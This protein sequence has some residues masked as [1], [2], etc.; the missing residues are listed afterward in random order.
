MAPVFWAVIGVGVALF[1]VVL[2]SARGVRTD[3]GKRMDGLGSEM[4]ELRAEQQEIRTELTALSGRVD[5][6]EVQLKDIRAEMAVLSG[7]VSE[8]DAAQGDPHR[9]GGAVQ[10]RER[11]RSSA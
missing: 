10:P 11:N 2:A 6:I 3:L 4:R 1:T 5:G 8:I 9:T 7:R